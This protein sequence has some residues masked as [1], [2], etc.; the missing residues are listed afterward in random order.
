MTRMFN[1]VMRVVGTSIA[2]YLEPISLA[3]LSMVNQSASYAVDQTRA[4]YRNMAHRLKNEFGIDV[5][6]LAR[7]IRGKK[8]YLSGSFVLQIV[9]GEKYENHDL[10]IFAD[11]DEDT[12]EIKTYIMSSGYEAEKNWERPED[13]YETRALSLDNFLAG[14]TRKIQLITVCRRRSLGPHIPTADFWGTHV[15]NWWDG[16]TIHSPYRERTL[17]R[18]ILINKYVSRNL[19]SIAVTKAAVKYISR[20]FKI[21]GATSDPARPH[22]LLNNKFHPFGYN[23][24]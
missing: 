19:D 15:M 12:S 4:M 14:T 16:Y 22:E 24:P 7:L 2:A 13:Y 21:A 3:R 10:D 11:L 9:L 6:Q 17:R 5:D 20:G 23:L 1:T 8:I 18:E